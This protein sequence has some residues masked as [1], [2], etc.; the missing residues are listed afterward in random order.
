MYTALYRRFRP[1]NFTQVVG[2]KHVV[3]ALK[4]EIKTGSFAHAYLFCG[5]RGTGKTSIARIFSKAVN[6]LDSKD[7]EPCGKC[8]ICRAIDDGTFLDIY[9]I[10]AASNNSVDNIRE[11]RDDIGFTPALGKYK[12]YIIDEVHMLSTSAFNAFL[13]TLE[14]PPQH[15]IFIL[16]TTDPQKV[17]DT[18]LSR[19]QRFDFRRISDEDMTAKLKEIADE[20]NIEVDDAAYKLIVSKADGALRDAISLFDKC[21]SYCGDKITHDDAIDVLGVFDYEILLKFSRDIY[22]Y[23]IKEALKLIEDVYENGKDIV[24]FVDELIRHYRNLMLLKVGVGDT[25]EYGGE[26]Y[27]EVSEQASLYSEK[28]ITRCIDILN[29]ASNKMKWTDIPRITLEVAVVRI[30]EPQVENSADTFEERLSKLEKNIESGNIKIKPEEKERVKDDVKQKPPQ[31]TKS[32]EKETQLT[33]ETVSEDEVSVKDIKEK[34][35]D[36]LNELRK[37]KP[38]MYF[39]MKD[40]KFQFKNNGIVILCKNELMKNSISKKENNDML[41]GI[42]GN[43]LGREIPFHPEIMGKEGPTEEEMIKSIKDEFG[44]DK[45]KI[46]K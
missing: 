35:N 10:D 29:E 17:P 32:D 30:C 36:V 5:I 31:E 24:K 4:N 16:A 12:V 8:E 19:C 41:A 27:G 21:A 45:V 39:F 22:D 1:K 15:V 43:I 25:V 34:W 9:E 2:Q 20:L 37:E 11:I 18:I 38:S 28:R 6:C 14:E 40:C 7:G 33:D 42:I 46:I 3:R 26:L 23:N 44:A 13:K